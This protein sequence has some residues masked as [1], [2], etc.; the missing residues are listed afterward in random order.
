MIIYTLKNPKSDSKLLDGS[1][2]TKQEAEKA[3]RIWNG[4]GRKIGYEVIKVRVAKPKPFTMQERINL[5]EMSKQLN[6][7]LRTI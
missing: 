4:M 1:F 7:V 3:L 6:N 2:N 5:T